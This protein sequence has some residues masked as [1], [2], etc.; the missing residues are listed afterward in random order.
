M[1]Y[2]THKQIFFLYNQLYQDTFTKFKQDFYSIDLLDYQYNIFPIRK[3]L[4]GLED[5]NALISAIEEIDP[6]NRKLN[7]LNNLKLITYLQ[8][9]I[10]HYLM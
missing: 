10:L 5:I 3:E 7:S 9:F 1:K 8:I 6:T 4:F 2:L